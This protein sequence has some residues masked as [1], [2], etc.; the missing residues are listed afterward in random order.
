M[1]YSDWINRFSTTPV[2][3]LIARTLAP[4]DPLVYR[5]TGGRFTLSIVKT[6]PQLALTT[7][8][9]RSGVRRV[10]QLGALVDG[11]DFIIVATNFGQRHHPAWS[12]NLLANPTATVELDGRAFDVSAEQVSTAEREALWPRLVEVIPQF[13]VYRERTV[14]DIRVF[15]LRRKR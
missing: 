4:Y 9:R 2:G 5:A 7:I 8:G 6:I 12:Y 11:D 14:R 1:G 10:V 3:S 13:A 15:R